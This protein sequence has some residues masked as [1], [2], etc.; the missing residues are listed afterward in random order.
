MKKY[1]KCKSDSTHLGFSSTLIIIEINYY[2]ALKHAEKLELEVV[3][4]FPEGK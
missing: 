4:N 3:I 2:N 1:V